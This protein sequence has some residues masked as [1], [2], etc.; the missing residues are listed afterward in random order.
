M[1]DHRENADSPVREAGRLRYI[2]ALRGLAALLVLWLHVANSYRALS[3]QTA[4]HARWLNDYVSEIDIGRIGVVVFFLISGFVIPFSIRSGSA[5]PI[6]SFAIRR[7]FRIYPAYWLSVPLAAFVFFWSGGRSFTAGDFLV[8]LTLLQEVFGVRDANPVYW[9]LLVELAFYALCVALLLGRSLQ[10]TRR[11]AIVCASLAAMHLL[12]VF[13]VWI[14]RPVLT[15][16]AAFWMLNLSVMFWGTLYRLDWRRDRIGML[17]LWGVGI[18]YALAL[19]V[20]S[21][22]VGKSLPIYTVS[23]AIGFFVFVA[24]TRFVRIETRL[25]DW[26]GRISYS[27]YLFHPI[28]FQPIFLWLITRPVGSPWRTQHLA[29]YL[30]LNLVLTLIAASFVFRFVER[31]MI[32]LGHRLATRYEQRAAQAGEVAVPVRSPEVAAKIAAEAAG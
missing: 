26:L 9:T 15:V 29:V 27:I 18:A 28:V 32:R 19:P 7:V 12:G 11:V 17:V 4:A 16:G 31:P 3:P 5:A 2:D 13:M 22:A 10:S 23:Y 8:N 6:G 14:G 21:I 1:Q 24:G 30:V 20:A 25:T